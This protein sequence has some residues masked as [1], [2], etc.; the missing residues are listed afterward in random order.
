M[1]CYAR[2]HDLPTAR[3]FALLAGGVAASAALALPGRLHAG[4][5]PPTRRIGF[6]LVG[7]GKL[8]QKQLIP[9]L[10]ATKVAKLTALVSSTSCCRT[11]CTPSTPSARCA[12]ANTST[13]RS[14]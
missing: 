9:A 2:G 13:A 3:P 11:R 8:S 1:E 14:R 4:A 5:A 10:R 12:P 7:I 6:A